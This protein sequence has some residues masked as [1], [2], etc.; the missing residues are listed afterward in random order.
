MKQLFKIELFNVEQPVDVTAYIVLFKVESSVEAFHWSCIWLVSI[1]GSLSNRVPRF[2]QPYPDN[3][4]L[5]ALHHVHSLPRTLFRLSIRRTPSP[6]FGPIILKIRVLWSKFS[7]IISSIC[8]I[9]IFPFI[10]STEHYVGALYCCIA[11]FNFRTCFCPEV[12]FFTK[13]QL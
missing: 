6:V 10:R 2:P 1:T 5:L 4:H 7:H 3:C 11:V 12:E 9:R 8:L 13:P